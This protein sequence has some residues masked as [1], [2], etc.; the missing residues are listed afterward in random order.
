MKCRTC[1][2]L[3]VIVGL[4]IIS[5][6]AAC[7]SEPP[8]PS[9]APPSTA[10][11]VTAVPILKTVRPA[12]LAG[13]KIQLSEPAA[14]DLQRLTVTKQEAEAIARQH[15]QDGS[16]TE[17]AL[18]NYA[19]TLSTPPLT[20]LCWVVVRDLGHPIFISGPPS[21]NPKDPHPQVL[22][23]SDPADQVH[24]DVVDAVTGM[25]VEG[26]EG[27]INFRTATAEPLTP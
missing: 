21:N 5:L 22:P 19:D 16:V 25:Y 7:R 23:P 4:L 9:V 10:A 1:S 6:A 24:I 12:V 3:Y 8:T 2:A 26:A 11:I 13:A 14:A 17:S 20:C 15:W 18:A 27:G